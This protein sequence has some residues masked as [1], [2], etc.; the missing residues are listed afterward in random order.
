[1]AL[2]LVFGVAIE[3]SS[4]VI[5]SGAIRS[6]AM[7]SGAIR[8]SKDFDAVIVGFV[9]VVRVVVFVVEVDIVAELEAMGEAPSPGPAGLLSLLPLLI[10]LPP[11]PPDPP[12]PPPLEDREGNASMS[13]SGALTSVKVDSVVVI[14][15]PE[16]G[17]T[18]VRT[19]R[20]SSSC[21]AS[22]S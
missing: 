22:P 21:A 16:K 5:R 15:P 3:S 6:G 20:T 7:Q 17:E 18:D 19:C 1:M 12:P 4:G 9:F 13:A 14:E 2:I 11:P 10:L 8:S